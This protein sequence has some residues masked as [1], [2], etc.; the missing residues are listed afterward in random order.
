[1]RRKMEYPRS[2]ILMIYRY[3]SEKGQKCFTYRGL[4]AW[5]YRK[6]E[7]RDLEWHTIERVIRKL[8]EDG[9]LDRVEL[10][11]RKVIFCW[12]EKAEKVKQVTLELI[13]GSES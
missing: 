8:A 2:Y 13:F 1:M 5:M 12:N 9:F 7:Y 10:S 11:P 4:R 3:L 6:P